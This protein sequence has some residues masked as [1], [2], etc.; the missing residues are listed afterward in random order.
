MDPS[1]PPAPTQEPSAAGLTSW[2]EAA[3]QV[4]ALL[5]LTLARSGW[6][7]VG[8][9]LLT[10]GMMQLPQALEFF[11]TET[12]LAHALSLFV[13][14]FFM[15]L[16]LGAIALWLVAPH[17]PADARP[18]PVAGWFAAG[19]VTLL[20]SGIAAAAQQ[21]QA[22]GAVLS[23]LVYLS[24]LLS[25]WS[26]THFGIWRDQ[27]QPGRGSTAVV[28]ACW[29]GLFGT[30]FLPNLAWG[31]VLAAMFWLFAHVTIA[32]IA[33]A[34][35]RSPAPD[36]SASPPSRWPYIVA[37]MACG[38]VVVAGYNNA[39]DP[40]LSLANAVGPVATL[41]MAL[42]FWVGAVFLVVWAAAVLS[43]LMRLVF[44]RWQPKLSWQW[45]GAL[46]S[47]GATVALAIALGT[48][49][50]ASAPV[51]TLVDTA[52][53][54]AVAQAAAAQVAA[55]PPPTAEPIE[56]KVS[57]ESWVKDRLRQ[58]AARSPDPSALLPVVIVAAEGGG[59]R[60]AYWTASVLAALHER[61]P[62]FEPSLLALSGVS[63][64][65]VGV[66]VYRALAS[67][68]PNDGQCLTGNCPATLREA[69]QTVLGDDFLSPALMALLVSEPMRD[70]GLV[71][72]AQNRAV[73]LERALESSVQRVTGQ[74][75]LERGL[76]TYQQASDSLLLPGLTDARTG[77]RIVLACHPRETPS[78]D[79]T[80]PLWLP[81][82]P[83]LSASTGALLSARFPVVSPTGILEHG[84]REYRIVDGGYSDNTGTGT[85]VDL[86]LML[87][88][89]A[90][91][92]QLETRLK[93]IV[94]VI[95]NA[96]P[97]AERPA[98]AWEHG[99]TGMLADPLAT[100]DAVRARNA[101]DY[102][103]WLDS[104][105]AQPASHATVIDWP[106]PH[107]LDAQ[108]PLGWLLSSTTA[109]AIADDVT[110]S[111]AGTPGAKIEEVTRWPR[112][113][114]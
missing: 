45:V 11:A 78:N 53:P 88:A 59:I 86:L 28:W 27:R 49:H 93:P 106:L 56:A 107:K 41:T 77:K 4:F 101:T 2:R 83:K 99:V 114:K 32:R 47:F 20:G 12:S 21:S 112:S 82:G 63:G 52:T 113:D 31:T 92:L 62:A 110:A 33:P 79:I 42:G 80:E 7:L 18:P 17:S 38:L 48:G 73:A 35:Y 44:G 1:L 111:L 90:R 87:H 55:T 70:L 23:N 66:T 57:T 102:R 22:P 8:T 104:V 3:S 103:R 105:A 85:A 74:P 71:P 29:L 64:G 14:A 46:C 97:L 75:L 65:S 5:R 61:Y 15:C 6:L 94:L 37:P 96:A 19:L 24:G 40:V 84:E 30:N 98:R 109:K 95:S 13:V 25:A 51:R 100:L 60:A 54:Q 81:A 39:I 16:L 68:R 67:A 43:L 58:M 72:S 91:D 26:S 10:L 69:V 76:C 50:M 36:P 34:D 9:L 108:Y 89:A